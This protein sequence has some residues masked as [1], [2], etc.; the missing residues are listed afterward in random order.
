M[1]ADAATPDAALR[2]GFVPGVTT[3]KWRTRWA[4]RMRAHLDV[5]EV[6]DA[7]QRRVLDASDADLCF[8]R[9]PIDRDGLHAIPLYDEVLVAWVAKDHPVAAF[10]EITLADLA[11]ET[12]LPVRDAVAIDRVLAGAVLLVPMSV[13]RSE[14]RRDLAYRPVTDAEPST[15]ALAWRVDNDHPLIDEFIGIVRGRTENSARTARERGASE[16]KQRTPRPA[17]ARKVRPK[18]GGGSRGQRPR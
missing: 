5:V 8:V 1:N 14:N 16:K 17:P 18:R 13:A 4:D 6:A 7:D 11:D 2:V 9:L 15:V 3:R 12:V 10:D